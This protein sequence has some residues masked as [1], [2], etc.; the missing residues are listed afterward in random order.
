MKWL[1]YSSIFHIGAR[2][3]SLTHFIRVMY[4]LDKRNKLNTHQHSVNQSASSRVLI[5]FYPFMSCSYF[6]FTR[7]TSIINEGDYHQS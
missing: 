7:L 2:T 5:F 6:S 3:A 4:Y 1:D